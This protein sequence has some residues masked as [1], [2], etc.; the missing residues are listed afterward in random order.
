[1]ESTGNKFG[2]IFQPSKS[3]QA[4]TNNSEKSWITELLGKTSLGQCGEVKIREILDD[5]A[6]GLR[7]SRQV[8]RSTSEKYRITLLSG[9][10]NLCKS[11]QMLGTKIGEA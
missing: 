2:E 8:L 6:F 3:W 7:K 4:L 10:T 11:R 5:K 1:M 9:K